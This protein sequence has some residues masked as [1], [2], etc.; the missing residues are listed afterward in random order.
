MKAD[1]LSLDDKRSSVNDN[2][3]ASYMMRSSTQPMLKPL[4][5]NPN[6]DQ[7]RGVKSM[8]RFWHL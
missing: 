4:F 8:E 3:S 7:R 5:Q 6:P 1:G 2:N